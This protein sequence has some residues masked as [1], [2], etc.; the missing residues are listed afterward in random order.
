MVSNSNSKVDVTK[1][2]TSYGT[3]ALFVFCAKE[4]SFSGA[5]EQLVIIFNK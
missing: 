1:E 4:F 5:Y 2:I 3:N